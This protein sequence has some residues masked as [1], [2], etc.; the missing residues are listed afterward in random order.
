[1]TAIPSNELRRVGAVPSRERPKSVAIVQSNYI[2]WKGYFDLIRAVDAFVLLDEVQF[3][4]RD[5][6]NRNRIKTPAGAR[7]LSIPVV[8]KGRFIQAIDETEIAEAWADKHWTA[9]QHSYARAPH[10]QAMAPRIQV[11]YEQAAE[12]RLL[13][14]ANFILVSGICH[15]VG[16][17][18]PIHWSR[19]FLTHGIKTDRLLS[20]CTAIGAT[21]YLS[22]PAGRAYLET[23][24]FRECGIDVSYADYSGYPEYPQLYPPFD[25]AVTILD[26]IF[27]VGDDAVRYMKLI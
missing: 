14:R 22:G 16:I 8:S 7:W 2:P 24:K 5:W 6:R 12:E 9:L 13:S 26:L 4:K 19:D 11:L 23:D 10:F 15:L 21:H 17:A 1:M 3:T 25:H 27:H 20:I 18:T